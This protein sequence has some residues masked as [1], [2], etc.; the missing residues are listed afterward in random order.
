VTSGASQSVAEFE[1][2]YFSVPDLKQF[3]TAFGIPPAEAD[4]VIVVG[5]NNQSDP[6]GEAALDIQYIMAMAPHA[7]TYF[8]S[9]GANGTV[10]IDDILKWAYQMSN[11]TTRPM[12][13]SISYGMT[14]DNVDYYLGAGYL[15][16]SDTEFQKLASLGLTVIIACGDTGAGDLGPPPMSEPQCDV[17]HADWPSQSPYVTAIGSTY[18][19][20]WA[21][22][23]CYSSVDC[24][25]EPLGE[26]GVSV[27]NG[28]FWTTGGGYSNIT[29]TAWYQKSEVKQY[30]KSGA[31]FPPSYAWNA[32][33]RA[34][35]DATAVGHN[36]AVVLDGQM[37]PIDGT[38]A[39]APIFAGIITLLN[40]ARLLA[41]KKPLGLINPLLYHLLRTNPA[42]LNDVIVGENRCGA[43][44][45]GGE[46]GVTVC[47]AFGYE[48]VPGFDAVSGVG[49]IRYDVM[50]AAVLALP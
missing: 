43:Y 42:A 38:S 11:A 6:G 14:E 20:S 2:Q 33:G 28:L 41:G 39:S 45:D 5:P 24:S 27:S 17:L 18:I 46:P 26:V 1:Q 40:D 12:V 10:E 44:T 3:F 19:T 48:A 32:Q 21:E 22:P 25:T 34:Y 50:L 4:R 9:I 13:T 35:P 31:S 49:S 29:S 30:M 15:K 16:R 7:T 8:W 36:L 23:A 47:C 37:I